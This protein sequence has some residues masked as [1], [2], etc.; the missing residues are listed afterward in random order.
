[1]FVF[2]TEFISSFVYLAYWLL[3]KQQKIFVF[4]YRQESVERTKDCTY[5]WITDKHLW[6]LQSKYLQ[7]INLALVEASEYL[8]I[9]Y[10]F[11]QF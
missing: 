3:Q 5:N 11:Y 2:S 9:G 7:C 1:M 8:I 6:F 10:I 4:D